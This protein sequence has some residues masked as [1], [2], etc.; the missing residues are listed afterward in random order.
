MIHDLNHIDFTQNS[1]RLKR[2]Y[3]ELI[4][5]RACRNAAAV[6]T[7]SEFSKKRIVEWA[8]IPES[9]V[10]NIGNGVDGA[11]T[12]SAAPYAPGYPYLLCV[13]NRRTHKNEPRVL[14]AFAKAQI[15]PGIRL[16]LTGLATDA[17]LT[18]AEHLGIAQRLVFAGRVPEDELPS[19]YRG[20]VALVFPSLYE[21]FGLPVIEAMA[22]GTPVL[23]S[24]ST[25]LP[26]VAG[27]AALLV[28]PKSV[29]QISAGIERLCSDQTLRMQMVERGFKQSARFTWDMT[30]KRMSN[31]LHEI[32]KKVSK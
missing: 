30:T 29:E 27:D 14:E 19:Y 15:D 16:V 28:D 26:E 7:V 4:M 22:C 9:K 12:P 17:L 21:G 24:D 20:A 3:Y 10:V 18:Q 5:R 1:S 25:S 11:Y 31:V 2:I 13:S 8:R 6:I 32:N 23:T